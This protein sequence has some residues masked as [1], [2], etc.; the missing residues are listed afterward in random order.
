MDCRAR[1]GEEVEEPYT[2]AMALGHR[3]LGSRR[4]DEAESAFARALRE[5]PGDGAALDGA[6]RAAEPGRELR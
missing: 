4:W 6:S 2:A 1:S 3:E 5:R